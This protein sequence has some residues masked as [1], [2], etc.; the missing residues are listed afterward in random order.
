[1]SAGLQYFII[2]PMRLGT[3]FFKWSCFSVEVMLFFLF[4]Y[5]AY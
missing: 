4:V 2:I 1:M 3:D 5:S